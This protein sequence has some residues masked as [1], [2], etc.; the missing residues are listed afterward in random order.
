MTSKSMLDIKCIWRQK[1]RLD[2]KNFRSYVK[3]DCSLL[4]KKY[5]APIW[6]LLYVIH[7]SMS[8]V[9]DVMM[10]GHTFDI[11]THHI[12]HDMSVASWRLFWRHDKLFDVMANFL[13]SW[14]T[15]WRYVFLTSWRI[16]DDITELFDIFLTPW[17]VFDIMTFVWRNKEYFHVMTYFWLHDKLFDVIPYI[18]HHDELFDVMTNFLTSCHIFDI[19]TN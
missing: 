16:C 4:S 13:T 5:L 6:Q 3:W 7:F 18:W 8:C 12:I 14:Q 15:F 10:Y 17:R 1:I 11:M 19:M 2:V 9:F